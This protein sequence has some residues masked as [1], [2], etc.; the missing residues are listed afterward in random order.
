MLKHS[1]FS[2]N[3][4][5]VAGVRMLCV[6]LFLSCATIS[7]QADLASLHGMVRD[8]Q[9]NPVADASVTLEMRGRSQILTASTDARG[10]YSFATLHDGLYAIRVAKSGYSD[11][12][13][14]AVFI[15]PR[16]T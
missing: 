9:G 6:L 15:A 2:L 3:A 11:A 8:A 4:R 1:N 5:L 16:E 10:S 14:A 13:V 7:Q 12:E